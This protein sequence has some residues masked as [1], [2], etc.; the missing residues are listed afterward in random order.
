VEEEVEVMLDQEHQEQEEQVEQ[1]DL[2]E[3]Q[4][5]QSPRTTAGT[6]NTG[7]GGGGGGATCFPGATWSNRWFRNSYCKSTRISKFRSKPRYKHS[8]NITRTSWWL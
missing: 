2:E 8:Y 7:G 5:K 6:V 3:L 1:V 4:L